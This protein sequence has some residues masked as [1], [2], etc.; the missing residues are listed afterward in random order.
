[1]M[2]ETEAK[3]ARTLWL[4]SG[5]GENVKARDVQDCSVSCRKWLVAAWLVG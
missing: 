5:L 1:M 3:V 2:V 4:R